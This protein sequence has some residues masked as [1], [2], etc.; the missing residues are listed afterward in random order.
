MVIPGCSALGVYTY[1]E[2]AS[3]QATAIEYRTIVPQRGKESCG[4]EESGCLTALLGILLELGR[5][6]TDNLPRWLIG[7]PN[8]SPYPNTRVFI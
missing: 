7:H 8:M 2:S 4:P 5:I 3:S 1:Q 6:I